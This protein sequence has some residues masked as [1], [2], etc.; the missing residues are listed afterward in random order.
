MGAGISCLFPYRPW[1]QIIPMQ[2]TA[3]GLRV[4]RDDGCH[5]ALEPDTRL[6]RGVGNSIRLNSSLKTIRT[7]FQ[8]SQSIFWHSMPAC[9][10]LIVTDRI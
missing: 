3:L 6:G 4:H 7:C 9:M 10:R 1:A 5:L 8:F 2:Q